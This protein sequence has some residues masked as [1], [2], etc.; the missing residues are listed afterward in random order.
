MFQTTPGCT[1]GLLHDKFRKAPRY[2]FDN[3]RNFSIAAEKKGEEGA[4]IDGWLWIA[5]KVNIGVMQVSWLQKISWVLRFWVLDDFQRQGAAKGR[6]NKACFWMPDYEPR[7]GGQLASLIN[8]VHSREKIKLVRCFCPSDLR[9]HE[10]WCFLT[11]KGAGKF[12]RGCS[13]SAERIQSCQDPTKWC[14]YL[15]THQ[16]WDTLA[17][18]FTFLYTYG[19]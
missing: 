4:T 14:Y 7:Y 15:W 9:L 18:D 5:H 17:H 12:L 1:D 3:P 10:G 19:R 2:F 13:N 6:C 8:G 16:V 11:I